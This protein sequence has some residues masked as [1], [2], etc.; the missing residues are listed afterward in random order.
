MTYLIR[1]LTFYLSPRSFPPVFP[2]IHLGPGQLRCQVAAPPRENS[3]FSVWAEDGLKPELVGDTGGAAVVMVEN[4]CRS[5]LEVED[6]GP[7]EAQHHRGPPVHQV[8]GVDV[9]QL[10]L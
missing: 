4:G 3:E 6:D 2:P 7:Y 8:R 5:Y 10:D 1:Q 9:H